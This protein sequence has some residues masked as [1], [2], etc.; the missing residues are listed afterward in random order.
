MVTATSS[1]MST[2]IAACRRR[3]LRLLTGVSS[4]DSM[5]RRLSATAS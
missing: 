3:R 1:E 5:S 2:A 4:R